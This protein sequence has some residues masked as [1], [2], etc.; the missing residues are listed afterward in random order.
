MIRY[1]DRTAGIG[2]AVSNLVQFIKPFLNPFL[3]KLRAEPGKPLVP[4]DEL[5]WRNPE[6]LQRV[7]ES[8]TDEERAAVLKQTEKIMNT[9]AYWE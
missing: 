5:V 3:S 8:M 7:L 4:A 1:S 9:L 2:N 6:R